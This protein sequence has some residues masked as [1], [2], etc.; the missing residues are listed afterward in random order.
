MLAYLK[1]KTKFKGSNF[2]IVENQ[3]IGYKVFTP[4]ELLL[5]A[6][7]GDEI[8][9]YIYHHIREDANQ[10]YG[11]ANYEALELFE[12]LIG[13][14]GVGPK[15]GLSVFSVASISDLKSAIANGN[16]DL[17]KK[18][19]GIGA[20]TAERLILELKNKIVG[21]D[22]LK[23]NDELSSDADA[24]DALVSLGYDE[25]KAREALKEVSAAI[26]DTGKRVKEALRNLKS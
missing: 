18:V 1:G 9:L 5:K 13:V 15:T 12:L 20:K 7:E 3:G 25:R 26:V 23:S 19:S 17:L 21:G 10:L 11:F 4:T 16:A 6:K 22:K 24:I 8:E 2:L 14:S